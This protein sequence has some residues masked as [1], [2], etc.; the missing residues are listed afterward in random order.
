MGN[1]LN[2]SR[3]E[4]LKERVG[5]NVFPELFKLEAEVAALRAERDELR[6]VLAA[7]IDT[8]WLWPESSTDEEMDAWDVTYARANKALGRGPPED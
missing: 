6:S 2:Q 1:G 8:P 7:V 3:F 4:R 5:E